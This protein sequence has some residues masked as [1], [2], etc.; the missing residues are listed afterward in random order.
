MLRKAQTV[1]V[2]GGYGNFGGRISRTLA[3]SPGLRVI[4]A[5]RQ[6]HKAERLAAE[7]KAQGAPDVHGAR[8]DVAAPD[9]A[10]RLR[11]TG[12]DVVVHACGPFQRRDY[13]VARACV[14]AGAHYVD[15]A[16]D[17][18]FVTG[19][20][21]LHD[22]AAARGV[23]VVSGASSV[24]GLSGAVVDACL[25]RFRALEEIRH[26][27]APGN[28]A[29]RGEATV[30]SILSYA[31]RP[32]PR[33]ERGRWV[34]VYGWQEL[35]R[36]AFPAPVGRRWL[37][38]CDIPDLALFPQ[39]YPDVHTVTFHAGLELGLLHLGLWAMSGLARARLID[40]W[41]RWAPGITRIARWFEGL[42][43]DDGAMFVAMKGIGPDGKRLALRWTLIA[44]GGHGPEIPGIAAIVLVRKLA[45]GTLREPGARP[46]LGLFTLDE[47]MSEMKAWKVH[48]RLEEL[49]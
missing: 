33:F 47:F 30:A 29:P 35:H 8:F 6:A 4:I 3:R 18:R 26:G 2:L 11:R 27:I 22:A 31:G 40:N 37:A 38:S 5:G 43:S 15:L 48:A 14:D 10:A 39:R 9:L 17:R 21:A 20:V 13:E 32:F 16:D 42:G 36:H 46:C 25:P 45:A 7:L 44:E 49:A 24:P 28:R 12:A 23:L 34:E 19:I 1:L 41:A